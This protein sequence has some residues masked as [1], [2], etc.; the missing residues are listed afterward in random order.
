MN[1]TAIAILGPGL[2]P[3]VRRKL[4]DPAVVKAQGAEYSPIGRRT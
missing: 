3:S 4:Y 2:E 1:L